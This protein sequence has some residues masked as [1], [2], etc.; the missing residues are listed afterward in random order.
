M[1]VKRFSQSI[2]APIPSVFAWCTGF[3]EDGT[4][5][6]NP[7]F[8]RRVLA[9]TPSRCVFV[10]LFP[11]GDGRQG[12]GVNVVRLAPPDSWHLDFY[13][14]PRGETVDY[15][16]TKL[17]PETTRLTM[18]FAVGLS[19]AEKSGFAALWK[20]FA[21]TMENEYRERRRVS[22]RPGAPN[23]RPPGSRPKRAGRTGRTRSRR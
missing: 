7:G 14:E 2:R 8:E 16:L 3:T 17:G 20:T 23:G 4:P 13:G 19:R 5:A 15:R 10:D 22:S 11:R 1:R 6:A 21:A 9:Q 12:V 18:E